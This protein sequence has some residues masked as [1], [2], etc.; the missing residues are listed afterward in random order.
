LLTLAV[1]EKQTEVIDYLLSRGA[2][3]NLANDRGWTP[4]HAAAYGTPHRDQAI[5]LAILQRLLTAG[6]AVDIMAHGDGGTPLMQALFWGNWPQA[7]VLAKYG[8]IPNNLRAASGLGRLDLV[9]S[10]FQADGTLKPEAGRQR[11]FHRPHSGFPAWIATDNPQEILDEALVYACKS[12]RTN[13]LSFLKSMGANLNGEPYNGTGLF[14]AAANGHL[15]TAQWLLDHD[16][17][18]HQRANFGGERNL[19]VLHLAAWA[20]QTALAALLLERGADLTIRDDR[21]HGLPSGWAEHAGHQET[22]Q[23]LKDKERQG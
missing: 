19:T 7:E 18:L 4:L 5:D 23:F 12:N 1:S 10:F 2:A 13:V 22:Y 21:Y 15:E 17:D 16:A 6:A 8:I 20:G 14:W 11:E 9:R 3:V